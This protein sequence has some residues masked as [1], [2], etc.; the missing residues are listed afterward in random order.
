MHTK[1]FTFILVGVALL[2]T[3]LACGGG[4]D[5]P[6]PTIA[7]AEEAKSGQPSKSEATEMTVSTPTPTPAPTKTPDPTNAPEPAPTNMPKPTATPVPTETP[8]P[9]PTIYPISTLPPISIVL[10]TV[11][12][13]LLDCVKTALG[14][15]EYNAI[16]G[17]QQVVTPQQVGTV[18]PCLMQYPQDTK[19]AVDM[20]GLDMGSIMERR[21][22]KKR[23]TKLPPSIELQCLPEVSVGQTLECAFKYNGK[24]D[25]ITWSAPGGTPSTG[26]ANRFQTILDTAGEF[27]ISLEACRQSACTTSVQVIKVIEER[28][29]VSAGGERGRQDNTAGDLSPADVL[30]QSRW[31]NGR[32]EGEGPVSLIN[33][34]VSLDAISH[35]T[36]MGRMAGSHVTPTD[37]FYVNFVN[38]DEYHNVSVMAAGYVVKVEVLGDAGDYRII[39]EHSCEFYTVYIHLD[40][41]TPR[42]MDASGELA[43]G[44]S[45]KIRVPVAAGEVIGQAS[46][47]ANFDVSVFDLTVTL[48][49]FAVPDS[50]GEHWKV[51]TADP[52]DHFN[53]SIKGDLLKKNPRTT[54]PVGGKIDYDIDGRLVGNWFV[55]G[56][57]GYKTEEPNYWDNHLSFAYDIYDP[58]W[59]R[60]SKGGVEQGYG[61]TMQFGLRDNQPDPATIS[62]GS[63]VV[64]LELIDYGYIQLSN[65]QRWDQTMGF[66]LGGVGRSLNRVLGT[67]LVEMLDKRELK[68]E[69]FLDATPD[70][71][72]DFTDNAQIY[73]R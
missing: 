24:P 70:Q 11:S 65:N 55:K 9:T 32:C 12:P 56:T 13:E 20:L 39:F 6:A 73:I 52:F 62:V 29:S 64:K 19:A 14:D 22:S 28:A 66:P 49:G 41:L 61:G 30:R 25:Q 47:R 38:P 69:L 44:N 15:D 68:A 36:P 34:P 45:Q 48:S 40:S 72:S 46:E 58:R 42:I 23:S 1:R 43:S 5:K 16:I 35:I 8:L 21:S 51:Y 26:S 33:S 17:G 54:E 27:S 50:Y 7:V 59:I 3:V 67:M 53:E 71:V 4:I 18:M 2:L 31:S 63:G 57:G 60:V 10:Q 37:H